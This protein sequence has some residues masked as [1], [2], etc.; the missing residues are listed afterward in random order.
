MTKELRYKKHLIKRLQNSEE[1]AAYLSAAL[2]DG[3]ERVLLVAKRDI[4][5]AQ[6]TTISSDMPTK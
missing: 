4:E 6:A 3:D 1:A 5:E 2:E